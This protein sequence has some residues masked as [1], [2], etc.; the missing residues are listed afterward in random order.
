MEVRQGSSP[1][2]GDILWSEGKEALK[3]SDL[4]GD[5]FRC[6]FSEATPSFADLKVCAI[7]I[8]HSRSGRCLRPP[9]SM[10]IGRLLTLSAC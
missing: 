10:K 4:A 6:A 8:F 1:Y 7:R 2:R 9:G 5:T 3:K